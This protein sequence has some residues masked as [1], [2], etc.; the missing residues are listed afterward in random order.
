[1]SN[2]F[3]GVNIAL[4]F[5]E[6]NVKLFLLDFVLEMTTKFKLQPLTNS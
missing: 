5:V 6:V 1:M 3:L 2:S 4:W